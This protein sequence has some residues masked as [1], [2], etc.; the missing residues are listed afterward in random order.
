MPVEAHELY[1]K[2]LNVQVK[3]FYD[4]LSSEDL[5]VEIVLLRPSREGGYKPYRIIEMRHV[6]DGIFD[7]GLQ[8][9]DSG[10][11]A[12]HIRVYPTHEDLA[13][14]LSMGLLTYL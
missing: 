5:H 3:V 12:Y 8:P 7:T 1:G 2:S 11:F 10:D 13:H 14:P 9:D 6:D 4:G